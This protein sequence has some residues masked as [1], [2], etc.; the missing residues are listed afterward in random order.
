METRAHYVAVGAFVMAMVF[1]AFV[2]VLWLAGTQFST[3]FAHYY[4]YFEGPVTGLSTGG[5]V[6][7]NGIPVGTVSDIELISDPGVLEA[8]EHKQ[9]RVTLALKS[10]V[11]IKKDDSATIQ[12]NILSG[13]SYIL[14]QPGKSTDLLEAHRGDY[15]P[16][17]RSK[18]ATLASLAARGPLLLDKLDVILDHLDDVL[19]D[20]NRQAFSQT[21]DNIQKISHNL[22][23]HSEEIASNAGGA[24][25]AAS[26]L[27]TNLDTSFSSQGGLKDQLSGAL[28]KGSVALTDFDK[29]AKGLNDTNKQLDGALVDVRPGIRN[30]SQHT[31]GDVDAL[32]GEARQFISG[33]GRFTSQLEHDPSRLLFGDR[34]EGYQPK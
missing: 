7:Y 11:P 12:T 14:I 34:R 30:F 17:I 27:F 15:Y 3:T 23:E 33:L 26:T 13:V 24:L 21:L 32:V 18:R 10:S 2:A 9:V 5:R 19:S 25:K 8:H 1:L 4:I 29:L 22:S 20:Q 31:L 6:E 28:D 16:V